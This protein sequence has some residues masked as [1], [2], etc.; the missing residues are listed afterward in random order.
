MSYGD[1]NIAEL[2]IFI[3]RLKRAGLTRQQFS[4]IKGQAIAGDLKGA[5]KGLQKLLRE[6]ETRKE[7]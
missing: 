5:Q 4:T 7:A 6:R 3:K 1:R 2:Q